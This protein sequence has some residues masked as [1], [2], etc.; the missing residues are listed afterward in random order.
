[1]TTSLTVSRRS[2]GSP[3]G[4]AFARHVALMLGLASAMLLAL[5]ADRARAEAPATYLQRVANELVTASRAPSPQSFAAVIRRHADVPHIGMSSLGSYAR[6]LAAADR[7]SY[8]SGMVNFIARY[9]AKE[10]PKYPVASA[11]AMSQTTEDSNGV[12]VDSRITLRSG[13]TYDVRWWLVR[14]GASFKVRDAQVAGFWMSPFLKNLFENYIGENGGNPK[15][16]V[17][18]LNR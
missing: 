16:L 17:V 12:Y 14:N 4:S 18:A 5:G 13:D 9:A 3:L 10:A 1:M 8:F 11:I 2:A 7:Q 6:V 15:A